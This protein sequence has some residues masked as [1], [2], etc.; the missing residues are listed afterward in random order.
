MKVEDNSRNFK[1]VFWYTPV[2]SGEN[3]CVTIFHPTNDAYVALKWHDQNMK[4]IEEGI[5]F[6]IHEGPGI[7]HHALLLEVTNDQPS[8][9]NSWI[10]DYL[11]REEE[12]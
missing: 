12:E 1:S 7:I 2:L 5:N 10:I 8:L 4:Y 11:L 9:D 3:Q 6:C